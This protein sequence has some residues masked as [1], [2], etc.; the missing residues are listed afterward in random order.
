M[1]RNR[2]VLGSVVLAG[3]LAVMSLSAIGANRSDAWKKDFTAA[4]TEAKQSGRPLLVHFSATW[5]PP[6]KTM[7]R[8]VLH[9]R[10]VQEVLS[11]HFVAVM[12][13]DDA[14]P[15]LGVQFKVRSLPSDIVVAPDG[16]VLLRSEG[17]QSKANYIA[18]LR[19]VV[20]QSEPSEGSAPE[21]QNPQLVQ[22][23]PVEQPRTET[24]NL[25]QPLPMGDAPASTPKNVEKE[26]ARDSGQVRLLVGLDRY[27]PVS[28]LKH[29]EWRKGKSEFALQY[30]GIVYLL[31]DAEEAN[32][33][34][35]DPAKYA[36]RLLG[37]DPVV[38]WN[39]D[40]A[41]PG[42]TQFGAYFDGE[43]YLFSST[44]NRDRFKASPNVYTRP[45]HALK[46]DDI[47]GGKR[48]R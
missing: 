30:Q 47:D 20:S 26:P 9:T 31:C 6:C 32:A 5:C 15:E 22:Q 25:K 17:A 10:D 19:R 7:E 34:Q 4:A 29:R 27:S 12:V 14:E 16:V 42:S 43:L 40:R 13:D 36:P 35:A 46:V 45:Q 44:E 41:I 38:L 33:F 11:K 2:M 37:C 23:E 3:L 28:L 39:A 8:D 24:S 18:Q 1:S 48:W 21:R